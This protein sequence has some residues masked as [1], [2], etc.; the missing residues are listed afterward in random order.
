MLDIF[1]IECFTMRM[2]CF[3]FGYVS[4]V[5]APGARSGI[6]APF[7]RFFSQ[8]D[9]KMVDPEQISVIFKSEKQKKKKKSPTLSRSF[10]GLHRFAQI[11]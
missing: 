8:K 2:L 9:S 1:E 7:S 5:L 10:R 4:G 6:R 3:M 11:P